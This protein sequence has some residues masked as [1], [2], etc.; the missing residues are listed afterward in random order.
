MRKRTCG[1]Q[2]LS[3][4]IA[5]TPQNG[6]EL[7]HGFFYEF[8]KD[9]CLQIISHYPLSSQNPP[10]NHLWHFRIKAHHIPMVHIYHEATMIMRKTSSLQKSLWSRIQ[11]FMIK[12]VFY[13]R[14]SQHS[15]AYTS[16]LS[17]PVTSSL[18]K[19]DI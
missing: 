16:S 8:R 5:V 11:S 19:V 13:D 14:P 9:Q 17:H 12:L 3:K 1:V 15:I 2:T 7:V 6:F 4:D 18:P 10:T